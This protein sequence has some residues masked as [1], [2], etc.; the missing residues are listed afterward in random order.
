MVFSSFFIYFEMFRI[1]NLEW[2]AAIHLF[3]ENVFKRRIIKI[4][5]ILINIQ[6]STCQ[7]IK[8]N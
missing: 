4:V 8:V 6:F 1:F 7:R 5:I 3:V 2:T